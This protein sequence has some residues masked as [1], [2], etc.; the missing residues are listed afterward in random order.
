M[1]VSMFNTFDVRREATK[2]VHCSL[3][4]LFH[5]LCTWIFRTILFVIANALGYADKAQ[6]F[7]TNIHIHSEDINKLALRFQKNLMLVSLDVRRAP[8]AQ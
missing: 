8:V 3:N 1:C 5:M 4:A 6:N 2:R 7:T